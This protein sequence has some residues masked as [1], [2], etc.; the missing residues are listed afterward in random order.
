MS[1]EPPQLQQVQLSVPP[2]KIAGFYANVV[3]VWNTGIFGTGRAPI[4]AVQDLARAQQEHREVLEA[5][6]SLSPAL[7]EQLRYLQRR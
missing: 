2:D 4:E 5:Q 6:K 7:A 1:H 3:S